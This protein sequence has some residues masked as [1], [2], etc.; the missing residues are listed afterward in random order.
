MKEININENNENQRLDKYLLKYFNN[1][2]KSFIY[3]MIRKKNIKLNGKRALGNEILK[4][5]DIIS[6]YISDETIGNFKTEK[7]IIKTKRDFKIIF[8]DEN[9]IICYKPINLVSQP[10]KENKENSLNN[11]LLYYLYEK[12]EYNKNDDFTPSIC[13]RLDRNTSGIVI[14]GKN[15]KAL[16]CI[17]EAFKNKTID[18]YY[19]TAVE[20]ILEGKDTIKLYHLKKDNKA[21][22]SDKYFEG[23][24]E[25]ITNYETLAIKDNKTLL[26]IN[27]LTGKTHQIR[28]SFEYIGYPILGDKKYNNNKDNIFNLK[29]QFLH[30]YQVT[31]K[32]KNSFL[33]YLYNKSFFCEY[34][35]KEFKNILNFFDYV[36]FSNY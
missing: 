18:K 20:G 16:Q 25:I 9:I 12:G 35:S 33:N 8:E 30:C 17:N 21:I 34:M 11:Q 13:N 1:A 22:I 14:F 7:E 2:P 31:F 28:A 15:F 26:K 36:N 6:L 23:A 24:K 10:D 4:K 3:K 19:I 27:L 29:N 32:E 5:N